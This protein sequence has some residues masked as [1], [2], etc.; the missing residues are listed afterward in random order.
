MS[1]E[2]RTPDIEISL[3]SRCA[4]VYY[5]DKNYLI[6]R[7]DFNQTIYEE[8]MMCRN[9]HGYD[10]EIWKKELCELKNRTLAEASKNE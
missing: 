8:C 1:D 5:N 10:F 3:C 7:K 2:E 4:S 6:K 9:P